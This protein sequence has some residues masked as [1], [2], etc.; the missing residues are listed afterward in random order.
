MT[1]VVSERCPSAW[2]W[3]RHTRAVARRIGRTFT[4]V[5]DVS[6]L[7]DQ[8]LLSIDQI[9]TVTGT[10]PATVTAL[11]AA[12]TAQPAPEQPARGPGRPDPHAPPAFA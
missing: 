3:E 2:A 5:E 9:A 4:A 11:L 6:L 8:L 10:E 12:P 7:H 1:T